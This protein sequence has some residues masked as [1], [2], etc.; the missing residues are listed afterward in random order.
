MAVPVIELTKV[1]MHN[2]TS[3]TLLALEFIDVVASSPP[4]QEVRPRVKRTIK[5]TEVEC[6]FIDL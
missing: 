4:P 6:F 3:C 1:D 2:S 5:V